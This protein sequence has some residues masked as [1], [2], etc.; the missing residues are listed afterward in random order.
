MK[1]CDKNSFHIKAEMKFQN[2]TENN[3]TDN[4]LGHHLPYKLTVLLR[5]NKFSFKYTEPPNT[6]TMASIEQRIPP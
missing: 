4:V 3:T 2:Y 6:I 5:Y 1:L